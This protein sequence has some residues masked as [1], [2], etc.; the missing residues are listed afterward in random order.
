VGLR[1]EWVGFGR[2]VAY[3][4]S[5]RHGYKDIRGVHIFYTLRLGLVGLE[6]SGATISV[7]YR[8]IVR[9]GYAHSCGVLIFCT[10]PMQGR[11]QSTPSHHTS[12]ASMYS[13]GYDHSCGV[14]FFCTPPLYSCDVQKFLYAMEDNSSYSHFPSSV[15][16]L[17]CIDSSIPKD[18]CTR[19]MYI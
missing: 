19:W 6:T 15:F 10:S 16:L 11:G 17:Q 9:H 1:V 5:V 8:Y 3:L 14:H 7:A 13:I 18:G 4:I 2:P 12:V